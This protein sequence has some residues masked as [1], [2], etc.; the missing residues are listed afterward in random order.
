MIF[1]K[2]FL[3]M[4]LVFLNV[5]FCNAQNQKVKPKPATKPTGQTPPTAPPKP[6]QPEQMEKKK[7]SVPKKKGTFGKPPQFPSLGIERDYN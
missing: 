2:Q 7:D 1:M 6:A 5:G 3:L 4:L